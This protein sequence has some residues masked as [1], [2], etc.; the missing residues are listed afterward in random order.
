L[1]TVEPYGLN[2]YAGNYNDCFCAINNTLYFSGY[3]FN[4]GWELWKTN[5]T[6]AGTILVKDILQGSGGEYP[7][8]LTN[9][10]GS[11]F[12]ATSPGNRQ[13]WKTDG[14]DAGTKLIIIFSGLGNTYFNERCV[15]A[16]KFFFNE[17]EELWVSD[18]I[19][20]GTHHVIDNGLN[21]VTEVHNLV[22]AGNNVFFNGY[23]DQYSYELYTG[24]ATQVITNLS[25]LNNTSGNEKMKSFTAS[26]LNN[27]V[28]AVMNIQVQSST[29]QTINLS[30]S[31]ENGNLMSQ[32]KF[33]V[34]KGITKLSANTASWQPGIYLVKLFNTAGD[35]INLSV[36]K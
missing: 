19:P 34:Q 25:V 31:N 26:L 17:D 21:G 20:D 16:G 15:A 5:G 3:T 35:A 18:G 32:Q 28:N 24:D 7:Q 2:N 29:Q 33:L 8:L 30:V 22:G 13:L 1:K 36:M 11:L 4:E 27:P 14:T 6:D 10:N 12:F 9:V 23:T